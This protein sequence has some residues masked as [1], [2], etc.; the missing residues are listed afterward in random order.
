MHV[1]GEADLLEHAPDLVVTPVAVGPLL[2]HGDVVDEVERG[3]ARVEPGV[4]RQVAEPATDREPI[5]PVGRVETEQPDGAG[6]G[7]S[8]V[9]S[10]RSRVVLP[11]PFGPSRPMTPRPR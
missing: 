9:A 6:S 2:E 7:P 5:A 10:I 1:G 4:L 8:T 3:E 11:A